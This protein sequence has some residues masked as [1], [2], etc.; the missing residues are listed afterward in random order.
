MLGIDS[1]ALYMIGKCLPLYL[2][3]KNFVFMHVYVGILRNQKRM[4]ASL[5]LQSQVAVIPLTWVL[6]ME[7]RCSGRA[8]HTFNL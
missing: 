2:H 6:G 3:I 4:L 1:R 5:A 7:L 8:A